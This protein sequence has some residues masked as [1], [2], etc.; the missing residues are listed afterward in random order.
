MPEIL[1]LPT[2]YREY[3]IRKED[4]NKEARTVALSFSS[5]YPVERYWGVE[6]LD[7]SPDSVLLD[8]LLTA[9]PL[10]VMHDRSKQVGIVQSA[11]VS[12]KRGH[13]EVRFGKAKY[14][15]EIFQDVIDEIRKTISAAYII[16]EMVLE[17]QTDEGPNE[18]RITKW[19][20][21]EISLE[22]VPADPTVGV[23]RGIEGNKKEKTYKA[24]IINERSLDVMTEDEK[25]KI[26]A[27][28]R[29]EEQAKFEAENKKKADD[30][31]AIADAE[32]VKIETRKNEESRINEII[33]IGD[34]FNMKTEAME[35]IKAGKSL[36]EFRA[37]A[38]KKLETVKHIDSTM[39][40]L[41]MSGG[42]VKDYSFLRAIQAALTGDWSKAGLEREASLGMAKKL[43]S[44]PRSFYVPSDVLFKKELIT[45]KR[46]ITT[47][48]AAGLVATEH[49]PQNF[50]EALRNKV[51]LSQLGAISLTG[52]QGNL[53]IPKQTGAATAYWVTEGGD[54]TESTP[55]F[56]ALAMGPKTVCARVD[57]TRRMLLQSNPSIEALTINDIINVLSLAI[58]LA[59]ISGSG[60]AG[61]PTGILNTS[62]IGDVI[63]TALDWA[64]VVEFETDVIAANADIGSMAYLTGGAVNGI[65]KTREKAAN[66]ARFLA[67]NGE[68][69][70]YKTAI[71]NA[72]PPATMLFGVFSQVI[73]GLWS[74][75]D[76]QIDTVTLGDSGGVVIRAFQDMDIGIRQAAAFSA[77]DEID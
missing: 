45:G 61:Q 18:Y 49:M 17:K 23:G 8:R 19:E 40:E 52:L 65:L 22:P 42:E 10:L 25:R 41:G 6:I 67:E 57:Y 7:H 27:D 16:H 44:A 55:T 62:G 9:G 74:A 43:K 56:G 29:A 58:D 24:K 59:G 71:T 37:D 5:E 26:E 54:V 35:A 30:E 38:L 48:G 21:L 70:G 39:G 31:R 13:A 34:Q 47:S 14:A 32:K 77:S 63:G 12:E 4:I 28:V 75:L 33:A 64:A 53:S 51:M 1:E 50:I 68:M 3:Q 76:I 66:T 15:D 60:A 11:N 20:P 73:I 2:Q 46:D 72:T 69:N 36:S